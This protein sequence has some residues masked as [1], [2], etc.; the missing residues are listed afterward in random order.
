[1]SKGL[2]HA[3]V[4]GISAC[5]TEDSPDPESTQAQVTL[6]RGTVPADT[7]AK[8]LEQPHI[9]GRRREKGRYNAFIFLDTTLLKKSASSFANLNS[10]AKVQKIVQ[11]FLSFL[12]N[13]GISRGKAV[14]CSI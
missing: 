10:K 5:L 6:Y 13:R 2:K 12:Q 8:S 4:C 3:L 9:Y 1:M 7:H 14:K 11:Y